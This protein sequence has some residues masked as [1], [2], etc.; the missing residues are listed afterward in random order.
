MGPQFGIANMSL[1]LHICIEVVN[2]IY[3]STYNWGATFYFMDQYSMQLYCGQIVSNLTDDKN[4]ISS[5]IGSWIKIHQPDRFGN[6]WTGIPCYPL[7]SLSFPVKSWHEVLIIYPNRPRYR[8]MRSFN[9]CIPYMIWIRS[10]N[11]RLI[12]VLKQSHVGVVLANSGWN[13]QHTERF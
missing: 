9:G 1:G 6:F 5:M 11:S 2:G 3:E 7:F 10:E 8:W 13:I 12:W 4:L